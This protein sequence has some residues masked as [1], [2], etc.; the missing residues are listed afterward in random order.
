MRCRTQIRKG[1]AKGFTERD[2]DAGIDPVSLGPLSGRLGTV[3]SKVAGLARIENHPCEAPVPQGP[4]HRAMQPPGRLEHHP[5]DP[6][7]CPMFGQ[8]PDARA[9]VSEFPILSV[10]RDVPIGRADSDAGDAFCPV[11]R[12]CPHGY[13]GCVPSI[14][15]GPGRRQ[16]RRV[17]FAFERIMIRGG[18]S[19]T[20]ACRSNRLRTGSRY[21][22][23]M[24]S[25]PQNHS[26]R[27]R[28][29]GRVIHRI[30]PGN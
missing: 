18:L 15:P 28:I 8:G 6:F 22:D 30:R 5:F 11:F 13:F 3:G 2:A 20:R 19:A 1:V 25:R 14:H 9:C 16:G 27:T 26:E 10:H 17:R 7:P 12:S 24:R 4:R 21:R 23:P 29:Q